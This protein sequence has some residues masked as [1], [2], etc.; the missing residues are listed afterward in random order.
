MGKLTRVRHSNARG[1]SGNRADHAHRPMPLEHLAYLVGSRGTASLQLAPPAAKPAQKS[2]VDEAVASKMENAKARHIRKKQRRYERQKAEWLAGAAERDRLKR[3]REERQAEELEQGREHVKAERQQEKAER[4]AAKQALLPS[5]AERRKAIKKA[6]KAAARGEEGQEGRPT[7]AAAPPPVPAAASRVTA[8][9]QKR[10]AE[11]GVDES[12]A[13]R[14]KPAGGDRGDSAGGSP[15]SGAGIGTAERTL[16]LG[17]RVLELT[18]GKGPP[19]SE[20]D[21]LKVA[22]VG[23]LSSSS[24]K[25]FDKGTLQ[26]R[27]GAGEVIKG[28]DIGCLGMRVGGKRRITVPP[29]A[30]Y[31][32]QGAGSD[33]PPH[34]TLVFDVTVSPRH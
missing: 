10:R 7:L 29:K 26:F 24:G 4:W 1:G 5:K 22:Y 25:V 19:V 16:A 2:A 21:R 20:R 31:G 9:P 28:W 14:V 6:K 8:Q 32:A 13:K 11:P 33:I 23:R 34:S 17:V 30:G 27:L 18:P 12:A 15:G 3:E